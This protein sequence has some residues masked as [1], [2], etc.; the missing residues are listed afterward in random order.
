MKDTY[1]QTEYYT[2]S[3][4]NEQEKERKV[5]ER[6]EHAVHDQGQA[7]FRM[8]GSGFL[9]FNSPHK[10]TQERSRPRRLDSRMRAGSRRNSAVSEVMF[11][12]FLRALRCCC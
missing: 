9:R 11:F 6:K 12:F 8:S 7:I 10:H 2:L 1:K 5:N 3:H 4:R